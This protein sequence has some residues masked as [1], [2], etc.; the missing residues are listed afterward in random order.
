MSGKEKCEE[1]ETTR[2]EDDLD[3]G[4]MP[5]VDK[6]MSSLDELHQALDTMDSILKFKN[7][8]L[9]DT[10]RRIDESVLSVQ[11]VEKEKDLLVEEKEQIEKEKELLIE[12]K[13]GLLSTSNDCKEAS[14]NTKKRMSHLK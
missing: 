14:K 13:E 9:K 1:R 5:D 3:N 11:A 2:P 12:E 8:Q 6:L 7:T 4:D 10:Q